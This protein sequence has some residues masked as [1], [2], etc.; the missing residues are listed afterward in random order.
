MR[1]YS[2]ELLARCT[3]IPSGNPA[4]AD[5]GATPVATNTYVA[6]NAGS[7]VHIQQLVFNNLMQLP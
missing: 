1:I 4:A 6:I 2:S 7:F 5:A 3:Q